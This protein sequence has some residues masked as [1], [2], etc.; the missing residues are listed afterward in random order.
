[1]ARLLFI[2]FGTVCGG[3]IGSCVGTLVSR[4]IGITPGP[5]FRLI[6]L[7]EIKH[8]VGLCLCILG[9]IVWSRLGPVN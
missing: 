8:T 6:D 9:A 3:L 4:L 7:F 2:V 5:L 1:M